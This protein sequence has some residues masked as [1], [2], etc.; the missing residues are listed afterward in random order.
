MRSGEDET[1]AVLDRLPAPVY[2]TD[3]SGR[4]TYF[5]P[6]CVAFAGRRPE[7]GRDSWCVTWKLY[8]EQGAFLP[9]DECP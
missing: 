6:A 8:T 3:R 7:V 2:V 1:R 4:I 5:N 9:H